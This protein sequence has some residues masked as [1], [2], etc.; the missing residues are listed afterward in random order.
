MGK[1]KVCN[2]DDLVIGRT[3]RKLRMLKG[4]SQEYV[5]KQLGITFQQIQKYEKGA[6]RVSGSRLIAI[7]KIL[8]ITVSNILGETSKPPSNDV[9]SELASTRQGIDLAVAWSRIKSDEWRNMIVH[10][11]RTVASKVGDKSAD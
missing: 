6:N 3:I 8:D 11:A 9:I 5:S 7:A 1:S 10:V 2:S 4:Y